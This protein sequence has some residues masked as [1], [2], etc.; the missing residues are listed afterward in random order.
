LRPDRGD[1]RERQDGCKK[2]FLQ[3]KCFLLWEPAVRWPG[4]NNLSALD[5]SH[6]PIALRLSEIVRVTT[7]LIV[8]VTITVL[9][10]KLKAVR[11]GLEGLAITRVVP[12]KSW[13]C[14]IAVM[15]ATSEH[16]RV[17]RA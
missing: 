1:E 8:Q 5:A 2:G 12:P 10:S 16:G 15:G 6:K 13:H 17:Q 9:I 3:H 11:R 4:Y 14:Q 7:T